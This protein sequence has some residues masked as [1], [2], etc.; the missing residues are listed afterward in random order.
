MITLSKSIEN[1]IFYL[2]LHDNNIGNEGI[3]SLCKSLHS[4][5]T[6]YYL[7]LNSNQIGNE[8]CQ[9]LSKILKYNQKLSYL[10]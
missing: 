5:K 1:K 8:G 10:K 6:L 4:E 3:L 7:D 9:A 2:D